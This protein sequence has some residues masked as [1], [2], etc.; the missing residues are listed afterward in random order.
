MVCRR[1]GYHPKGGAKNCTDCRRKDLASKKQIPG[2]RNNSNASRTAREYAD[3]MKKP[4]WMLPDT[5]P[6]MPPSN[7]NAL[8]FGDE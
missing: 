2:A 6:T 7:T 1:N 4:D 5:P 3:S 8:T